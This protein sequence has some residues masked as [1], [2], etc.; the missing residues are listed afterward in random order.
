MRRLVLASA[1]PRRRELL[2]QVGYALRC[3]RHVTNLRPDEEAIAYVC[4]ASRGK[5]RCVCL[6]RC[7]PRIHAPPQVIVLGADTVC[8]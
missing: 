1:S 4:S 6:R 8:P 5:K 7:H 3:V 2:T